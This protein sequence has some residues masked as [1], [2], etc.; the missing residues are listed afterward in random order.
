MRKFFQRLIFASSLLVFC[1]G[2]AQAEQRYADV[3]NYSEA[4]I[5]ALMN[6]AEALFNS[7]ADKSVDEPW[8][9]IL[10]G[11][12]IHLFNMAN[13]SE[14]KE[15]ID[16]AAKL[17]AY[18]VVDFK[19]C[20]RWMTGFGF[21]PASLPRFIEAIEDGPQTSSLLKEKGYVRF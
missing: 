3:A 8:P 17:D 19:V 14:H 6:K 18:G 20:K 5:L 11:S 13:Y 1:L 7:V 2:V 4:D 15:L 21:D 9:F 12:E 10:H 16:L